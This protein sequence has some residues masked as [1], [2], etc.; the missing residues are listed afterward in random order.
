M[1]CALVSISPCR[2]R[3]AVPSDSAQLRAQLCLKQ[4][5]A[6]LMSSA[7]N[8]HAVLPQ[9]MEGQSSPK[10]RSALKGYT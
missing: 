10:G 6:V 8:V 9:G 2:G 5:S 1:K 3:K 4:Q 7:P